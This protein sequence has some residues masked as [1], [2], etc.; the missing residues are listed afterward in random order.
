MPL[1][2][3]YDDQ[4]LPSVLA[5]AYNLINFFPRLWLPWDCSVAPQAL[6]SCVYWPS[7]NIESVLF[8]LFLEQ[9]YVSIF[10]WWASLI[11]SPSKECSCWVFSL[12]GFNFR[13][14]YSLVY[15]FLVFLQFLLRICPMTLQLNSFDFF[16]CQLH[17]MCCW[18]CSCPQLVLADYQ[19]TLTIY[20]VLGL[21]NRLWIF[22]RFPL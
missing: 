21:L 16:K 15:L 8:G 7:F 10:V 1:N 4:I 12:F 2:W 14:S 6:Q 19:S 20:P 18:L 13:F 17:C 22:Q 3:F 5:S 9:M 11:L